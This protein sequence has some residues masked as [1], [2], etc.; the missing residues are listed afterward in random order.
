MVQMASLRQPHPS[1][2]AHS[3]LVLFFT[4]GVSLTDWEHTGFLQREVAYYQRLAEHVGP[5]TFVTYGDDS[6]LMLGQQLDGIRVIANTN[7]LTPEQ[8]LRKAPKI[9]REMLAGASIL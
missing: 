5:I 2:M 4:L 9:H 6:D 8:F 7:R 3:G 1:K